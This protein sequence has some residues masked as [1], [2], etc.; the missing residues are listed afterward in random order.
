MFV[1][2]TERRN[3]LLNCRISRKKNVQNF[4][5]LCCFPDLLNSIWNKAYKRFALLGFFPKCK[6]LFPI[7]DQC[8]IFFTSGSPDILMNVREDCMICL[9]WR[10]WVLLFIFN[11]NKDFQALALRKMTPSSPSV[12]EITLDI[13]K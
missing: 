10:V 2:E 8:R 12:E 13:P 7:I 9:F 6:N 4:P 1:G 5:E 11:K 3:I